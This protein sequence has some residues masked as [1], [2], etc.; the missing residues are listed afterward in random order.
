MWLLVGKKVQHS[1][2]Q[3]QREI[4]NEDAG[5]DRGNNGRSD[6]LGECDI[7]SSA[8]SQDLLSTT[9]DEVKRIGKQQE[10]FKI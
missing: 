5:D 3:Q 4:N 1:E 10:I 6:E 7:I 2:T 9:P 8:V